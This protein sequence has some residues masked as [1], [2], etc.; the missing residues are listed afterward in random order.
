MLRYQEFNP[1]GNLN[2]SNRS[3]ISFQKQIKNLHYVS[4]IC[5]WWE[6]L[7][8]LKSKNCAFSLLSVRWTIFTAHFL[9]RQ[10]GPT[11]SPTLFL[12]NIFVYVVL[13]YKRLFNFSNGKLL[14][15]GSTLN[16]QINVLHNFS[17]YSNL[18]IY[19]FLKIFNKMDYFY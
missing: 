16:Y 5:N 17:K 4:I 19:S 11:F 12:L 18:Q 7:R 8:N 3:R 10:F 13:I 6:C 15:L 2:W 14:L 9:F 1:W